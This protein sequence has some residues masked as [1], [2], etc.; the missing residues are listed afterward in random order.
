MT[1]ATQKKPLTLAEAADQWEKAKRITDEQK[2]L[3]EEAATVLKAHF[4]KTGRDQYKG[5]I[6][7]V[8]QD[9]SILDQAAVKDHLGKRLPKFMKRIEKRYLTLLGD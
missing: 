5:R 6:G 4:A 7:L 2:P 1:T 9:A 8:T 3:L